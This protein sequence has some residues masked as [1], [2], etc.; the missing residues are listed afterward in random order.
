MLMRWLYFLI[1]CVITMGC[2]FTA[3]TLMHTEGYSIS[4]QTLITIGVIF[5]VGIKLWTF[6]YSKDWKS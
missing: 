4:W 6:D 3:Q 2:L 5:I 1:K